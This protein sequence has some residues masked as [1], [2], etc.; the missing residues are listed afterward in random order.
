MR[1][2]LA[3][4]AALGIVVSSLALHVHNTME[5][6]PC[7][8]NARWDCGIVNHSHFAVMHLAGHAVPVAVIGIAG[9]ALLLLLSVMGRFGLTFFAAVAGCIFALYLTWI[10]AH[11]LQVYCLY[12][13]ISQSIIALIVLLSMAMALRCPRRAT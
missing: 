6:E 13:V 7:D 12:C 8:I 10:E 9:Y 5:S 4:L 2:I 1:W 11:I 3:L